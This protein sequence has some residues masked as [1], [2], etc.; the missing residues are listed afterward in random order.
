MC[1]DEA[2]PT[3]NSC[4]CPDLSFFNGTH[5]L[6]CLPECLKCSSLNTCIECKSLNSH[7]V[8]NGCKCDDGFYNLT[9]ISELNSCLPCN[10]KCSKC[11][12]PEACTECKFDGALLEINCECR[13]RYFISKTKCQAC[14]PECLECA[15][16]GPCLSCVSSFTKIATLGCE[17]I[18]GYGGPN[19]LI[20]VDSC[21]KCHEDCIKCNEFGNCISCKDEN[22]IP[23]DLGCQCKDG[24]YLDVNCISCSKNCKEC[25]STQCLICFDTLA[26]AQ[27]NECICPQGTFVQ[28]SDPLKCGPCRSDCKTCSDSTTCIECLVQ[29]AKIVKIGCSCEIGYYEKDGKCKE[30]LTWNSEKAVC[31]FCDSGEY[32]ISGKCLK[33]PDLCTECDLNACASCVENAVLVN[34]QC[35]CLSDYE[36][37]IKCEL[38]LFT[39]DIKLDSDYN[40]LLTLSLEPH[41]FLNSSN[42]KIVCEK[43]KINSE[44]KVFNSKSYKIIMI[45]P[46]KSNSKINVKL[47]LSESIIS[48]FN[49]S[50]AQNEFFL[51]IVRNDSNQEFQAINTYS[52][53][54]QTSFYFVASI[55]FF[56][57]IFSFNFVSFWN[58]LNS[59]QFLVYLRLIDIKL[60]QKINAL[61]K[62]LRDVTRVFNMFDYL[63]PNREFVDLSGKYSEFGFE[64]YSIFNNVGHWITML[65]IIF[66]NNLLVNIYMLMFQTRCKL[67]I[68]NNSIAKVAKNF[69]YNAYIRFFIQSYL[70]IGIACIIGVQFIHNQTVIELI[71]YILCTIFI[72]IIMITPLIS[73]LFMN[74][75]KD[76]ISQGDLNLLEKYG[77]LFYELS[78]DH[79][80]LASFFYFF[81]FLKR[82]FFILILFSLQS[83]PL[84]QLLLTLILNIS[85]FNI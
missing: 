49:S 62:A 69:K 18:D 30:C 44:L 75:H 35:K 22:K 74:K 81:F 1:P 15:S 57:S 70:D 52:Q 37:Q 48:K 19:S 76:E 13:S 47:I 42:I 46:S 56:V 66:S 41:N 55:S 25:N 5:C 28:N 61:L 82:V 83:Y 31:E 63:I 59:I 9:L 72:L 36:G 51:E 6:P 4:I 20:S 79:G 71:S 77:S 80:L 65:M 10:E 14:F 3:E 27:N 7:I 17:C 58:F 33:C 68:F 32:F 73:I 24:Y 54:G 21:V 8:A 84:F 50:L 43:Y 40:L 39:V 29:G 78:K 16:Y 64:N 11:L 38:K 60:P 26:I 23:S 2:T 53:A 67:S 34:N 85:V 12:G 45:Y